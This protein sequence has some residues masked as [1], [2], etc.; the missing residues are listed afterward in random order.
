MWV[1]GIGKLSGLS[2]L[3][4]N[5]MV[6]I[7]FFFDFYETDWKWNLICKLLSRL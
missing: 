6:K 2:I 7:W 3:E 1:I 4:E 5:L